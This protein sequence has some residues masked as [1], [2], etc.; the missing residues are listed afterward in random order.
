M[1]IENVELLVTYFGFWWFETLARHV[2]VQHVTSS[3]N[4]L[5]RLVH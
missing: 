4:I 1:L 5:Q 2:C 3:V